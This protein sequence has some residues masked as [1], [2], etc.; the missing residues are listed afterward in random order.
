MVKDT[1]LN[2][3]KTNVFPWLI[4]K[5]L[6]DE[7][8][9]KH[10]KEM[11]SYAQ[12]NIL[13][14][15]IGIDDKLSFYPDKV[16]KVTA[17]DTYVMNIK[18]NKM[19]ADFSSYSL[20]NMSFPDNT[21]DTVITTFAISSIYDEDKILREIKRILKCDGKLILLEHG[22]YFDIYSSKSPMKAFEYNMKNDYFRQLDNN[23]FKLQKKSR[24]RCKVHP[25]LLGGYLYK[26]IA[27]IK[28]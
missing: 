3:Y 9:A 26:G 25:I 23:G 12:G 24:I 20:K 17:I 16:R 28:K 1:L 7:F 11:L 4:D 14:I 8:I 10:R 27:V 6:K 15:G 21:F 5:S 13:E 2:Y 18:S 22:K 19:E